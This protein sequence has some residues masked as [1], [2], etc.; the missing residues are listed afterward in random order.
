ME[1]ITFGD[2]GFSESAIIETAKICM[3]HN[4]IMELPLGYNTQITR[5]EPLLVVDKDKG[6]Q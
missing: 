3:A 4:F 2:S 6:L 1:N 5:E